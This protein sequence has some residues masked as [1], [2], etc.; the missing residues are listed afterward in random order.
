MTYFTTWY[1]CQLSGTPELRAK[2]EAAEA[3]FDAEETVQTPEACHDFWTA[4]M[5]FFL[6]DPEGP[7]PREVAERW[8]DVRYSPQMHRI[9]P[10]EFDVRDGLAG[11]NVPVLVI[12]GAED[13]IT[14]PQESEEIAAALPDATVAIVQGAGHF[15]FIETPERYLGVIGSWLQEEGHPQRERSPNL[16][17]GSARAKI[18]LW[19][20]PASTS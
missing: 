19:R 20:T 5:P 16:F 15:P 2:V 1:R 12:T 7:A 10:G 9:D 17:A 8:R 6:A 4:Q 18:R 13:R 11:V 14:R 3:V